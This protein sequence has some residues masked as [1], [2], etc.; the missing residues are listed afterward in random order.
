M[1]K[2]R[3]I[4]IFKNLLQRSSLCES[5]KTIEFPSFFRHE[6]LPNILGTLI[7]EVW[8]GEQKSEKLREARDFNFNTFWCVKFV[9]FH[10]HEIMNEMR[11]ERK[12]SKKRQA[13][14]YLNVFWRESFGTWWPTGIRVKKTPGCF[15]LPADRAFLSRWQIM[16]E[17]ESVWCKM[18]DAD[19]HSI[20]IS[21]FLKQ[22]IHLRIDLPAVWIRKKTD[23]FGFFFFFIKVTENEPEN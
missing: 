23:G 2:E 4:Y 16:R 12:A 9:M 14:H 19:K 8:E 20:C 1:R 22:R 21:N 7:F 17:R 15:F 13:N 11:K 5:R 6:N 10:V 3:E 18:K